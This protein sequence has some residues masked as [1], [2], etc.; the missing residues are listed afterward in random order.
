M[1]ELCVEEDWEGEGEVQLVQ[2]V[3]GGVGQYLGAAWSLHWGTVEKGWRK[4]GS[5][6]GNT[7][8]EGSNDCSV[9]ESKNRHIPV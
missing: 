3:K 7:E 4:V 5:K 8:T 9:R 6:Y 2:R 1:E